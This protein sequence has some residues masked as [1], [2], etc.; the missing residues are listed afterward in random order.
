MRTSWIIIAGLLGLAYLQTYLMELP[1]TTY[2]IGEPAVIMYNVIALGMYVFMFLTVLVWFLVRGL[3][4]VADAIK[5]SKTPEPVKEIK[6]P[7][8]NPVDSFK[9]ET[10]KVVHPHK[11]F[12]PLNLS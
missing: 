1:V 3:E 10:Q 9:V 8:P 7:V 12:K 5:E 2:G 6:S 4:Q 11:D